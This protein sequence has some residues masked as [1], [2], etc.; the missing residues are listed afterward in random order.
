M[1]DAA[2]IPNSLILIV[3]TD[4]L[5]RAISLSSSSPCVILIVELCFSLP[6]ANLE[7][8]FFQWP[9]SDKRSTYLF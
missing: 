6:L 2:Q 8:S 7:Q 3:I 5:I 9:F 1:V 4:E